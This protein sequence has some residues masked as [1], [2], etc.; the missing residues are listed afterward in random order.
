LDCGI[1]TGKTYWA[2]NNLK[3][4]TRDGQLNRILFLVNTT[5]LKDAII[6]EYDNCVDADEMWERT[7]DWGNDDCNKIGIMCYQRLGLKMMKD[8]VDF[9]KYIDVIC[10]DECDSVF[11]FATEAFVK[12]RRTDFARRNVSNMEV[13][14]VIQ[15]FSSKKEYMPLVLLGGWQRIIERGRIMCIGLS[16][17]PERAYLYY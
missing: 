4:F 10:W 7:S 14:S 17:S 12:A 2:I 6:N 9:L 15:D 3:Q 1:R 5:A 16:A 8:D 11:D 13:L